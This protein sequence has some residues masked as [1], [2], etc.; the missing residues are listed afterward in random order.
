MEKPQHGP[1]TPRGATGQWVKLCVAGNFS[2]FSLRW[3][4]CVK[5]DQ[6]TF[7]STLALVRG[8]IIYK[9]GPREYV[10]ICSVTKTTVILSHIVNL[11]IH[12][13]YR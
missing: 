1:H 7:W 6:L 4:S 13:K 3:Q 9:Y 2:I 5:C 8:F 11:E 10:S 12:K